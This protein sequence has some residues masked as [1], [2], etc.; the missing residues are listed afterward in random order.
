[1]SCLHRRGI[2]RHGTDEITKGVSVEKGKWPK[3][4]PWGPVTCKDQGDGPE[5]AE[6]TKTEMAAR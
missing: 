2:D 3:T 6:V 4:G 5:L 1:M